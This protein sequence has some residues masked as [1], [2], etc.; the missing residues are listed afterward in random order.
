MM[1]SSFY[2]DVILL[3]ILFYNLLYY[4]AIIFWKHMSIQ[5]DLPH[6]FLTAVAI[7]IMWIYYILFNYV[8]KDRDLNLLNIYYYGLL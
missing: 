3:H 7:S 5:I 6:S 1:E 2:I 4:S 8:S